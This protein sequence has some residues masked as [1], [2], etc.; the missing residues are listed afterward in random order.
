MYRLFDSSFLVV[1]LY[2]SLYLLYI[3]YLYICYRYL[4]QIYLVLVV[5]G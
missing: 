4:V 2:S 5:V 3:L 1:V